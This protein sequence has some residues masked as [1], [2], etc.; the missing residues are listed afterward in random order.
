MTGMYF[1]IALALLLAN[2]FFVAGEF[3]VVAARKER[4]DQLAEQGH[5][6]A[7]I[8]LRSARELSFMLAA[9]Q[10]GI[11]M[12]SLGLGFVAEPAVADLLEGALR[13]VLDV[14]ESVTHSIAF[15]TALIIVSFL[16]IVIGEMAPK[17]VAIAQPVPTALWLAFPFR[18]YANVFRPFIHALNRLAN[19][20]VRLLGVEPTDELRTV[21]STQEIRLIVSES[22]RGG[23]ID[24]FEER[25][26]SG[27]AIL[28]ERDAAAVMVPRTELTAVDA[29]ATIDEVEMLVRRTGHSRIPVF[30]GDLDNILGFVHIKDLLTFEPRS[31]RQRLPRDLIRRMLVVPESRKLRPLLFDMR[32]VRQHLALVVDEHGGTAGLVTLEDVLEELVGEIRDEHDPLEAQIERLGDDRYIVPG[33]IRIDEAQDRLGVDLPEGEYETVAGFLMDRL[34][35]IP[36]RRDVVVHDAWRIRVLSMHRRRVTRVLIEPNLHLS[37]EIQAD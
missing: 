8:A 25:L 27:I 26:L 29:A 2:A 5:R 36:K 21:H 31:D 16:H 20:G 14:P 22:A 12:T 9:A 33:T 13:P 4:L 15:T 24:R 18:L 19:A 10:L 34:G 1:A 7:R 35:R 11:T 32:R 6:R 30:E 37:R 3:A 23:L 17:N 28:N